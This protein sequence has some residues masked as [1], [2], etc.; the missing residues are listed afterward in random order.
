[1][2]KKCSCC[3]K[4]K[5]IVWTDS[6]YVLKYYPKLCAEC[7]IKFNFE[8]DKSNLNTCSRCNELFE[9]LKNNQTICWAC[10]NKNKLSKPFPKKEEVIFEVPKSKRS[11]MGV[12]P[13]CQMQLQHC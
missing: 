7:S 8:F 3:N 1:M 11:E 10:K 9:P 2:I 6:C 13:K 4:I 5:T 12:D